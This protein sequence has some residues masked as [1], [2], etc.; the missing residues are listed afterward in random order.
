MLTITAAQ[1]RTTMDN[2]ET[3][4]NS[5]L[6]ANNRAKLTYNVLNPVEQTQVCIGRNSAPNM[7]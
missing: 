3:E 4:L 5:V 2:N 6:G 1:H 7:K